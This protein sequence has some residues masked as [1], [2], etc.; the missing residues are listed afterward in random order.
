VLAVAG[1]VVALPFLLSSE[2]LLG[3]GATFP[4]PLYSKMFD[5]Y[6]QLY[7]VKVNY[8]GIGSGGG[9]RQLLARS[10]DFG[11]T[12]VP[13][14]GD[15]ANGVVYV[16]VAVGGVSVIYNIPGNPVLKLSGPVLVDIFS[17]LIT[18][19]DDPAIVNANPAVDLPKR[20]IAVVYRSDGSGTTAIF[21]QYL[22]KISAVWKGRVGTGLSVRWPVGVGAKGNA[23][24]T[25]LVKNLSGSI[26]YVELSYALINDLPRAMIK[27]KRGNFVLPTLESIDACARTG[28]PDDTV[29]SLVDTDEKDG[30]PIAGFTWIVLDRELGA[31]KMS[32]KQAKALLDLVWWMTHEGQRFCEPLQ[33]APLTEDVQKKA[34]RIIESI[35][36]RGRRIPR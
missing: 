24:V 32:E 17:G 16:P 18:S 3:A 9:I 1:A 2:Q 11:G 19:W 5:A 26:G 6:Y 23:G 36:Y 15:G 8:Q 21:T 28:I 10:V 30:Y 12:D 27:N 7:G 14:T 33:Y 25:G 34:E 13:I 35:T 31:R 22:S 4:Q 29:I 20:P